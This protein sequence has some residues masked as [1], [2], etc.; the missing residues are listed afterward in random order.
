MFMRYRR[1]MYSALLCF[2]LALI[3][4]GLIWDGPDTVI[5]GIR[6]ILSMPDL[7][8]TDYVMVG[9]PGAA[10]VNSGFVT[11]ISIALLYCSKSPPTAYT[12]VVVGL[13]S[14]FSLFGKNFVNIL[15][16]LL[17][18][19]LYSL[20]KNE[21]FSSYSSVTLMSTALSPIVSYIAHDGGYA[22]VGPA[23]AAGVLIGFVI[24]PLSS[25]TFKL[26]SG[27]NLYNV[28]FACGILG[29]ILVPVMISSGKQLKTVL[30]WA[31][32]YNLPF[33]IMIAALCVLLIAA[34]LFFSGKPVWAVWAG[35]R[36]LLHTSGRA[37]SDYLRL[38]GGGT[39]MLNM[40]INGLIGTAY[41]LII[42]GDLNG[43]TLAG[44]LCVMGF[45]AF[46]KHMRNIVPI[47][48][49]VVL[50]GVIMPWSLSDPSL[51]IAGL[52]CTTLAPIAGFF[53]WPYGIL[54]GFLHSSVVLTTGSTLAGMNLYN[55]GF[56]GGLV[57]M[58]LY[59]VI[60]AMGRHLKPIILE[61]EFMDIFT[62][63]TPLTMTE[64][65]LPE[66]E[67]EQEQE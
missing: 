55:N 41:I 50:G 28:G 34:G 46:G 51:Q 8:I 54:A 42:G 17:G 38:F 48:L 61:E 66:K 31:T 3:A 67:M 15:P 36:R 59:P 20:V 18:G 22:S 58:V 32:G 19:W 30:Y 29:M 62:E 14:G 4:A 35:Y 11:L 56:S 25:Y 10:L 45:S 60:S 24:P 63:S 64:E 39:V 1:Q 53:G 52:F 43:P 23:I 13:M 40:G 21:P 16:I 7:L 5:S 44:I 2:A 27:M 6:R 26:Q 12:V 33:G 9:G 49:G 47:M 65:F 37:P 57:A